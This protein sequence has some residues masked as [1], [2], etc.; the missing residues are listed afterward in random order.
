MGIKTE[1][2]RNRTQITDIIMKQWNYQKIVQNPNGKAIP[3]SHSSLNLS[4][5]EEI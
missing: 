3:K 5:S 1:Y 4:I 2:M